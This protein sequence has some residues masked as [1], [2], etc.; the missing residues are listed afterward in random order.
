MSYRCQGCNRVQPNNTKPE[1]VVLEKR[2]REYVNRVKKVQEDERVIEI[3]VKS[4]GWEIVREKKVCPGCFKNL[5]LS[6]A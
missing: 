1:T 5:S 4:S 3:E 6:L 2:L